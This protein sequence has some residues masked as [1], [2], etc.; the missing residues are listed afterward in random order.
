MEVMYWIYIRLVILWNS[1]QKQRKWIVTHLK[2][3][4]AKKAH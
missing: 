2:T 3:A 1:L 4:Q